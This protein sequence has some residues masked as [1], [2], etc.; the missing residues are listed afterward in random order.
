MSSR[1]SIWWFIAVAAV[2]VS[3]GIWIVFVLKSITPS[4]EE[5][6]K[7]Y[8]SAAVLETPECRP[9][10]LG[11][12]D[13]I[14]C[15]GCSV[16]E[17]WLG[18]K[19]NEFRWTEGSEVILLFRTVRAL[20]QQGRLLKITTLAT[21]TPTQRM[22]VRLNGVEIG[23]IVVKGQSEYTFELKKESLLAAHVNII[24]LGLPDAVRSANPSDPRILGVA[25][26]SV[27]YCGK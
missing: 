10:R 5:K 6:R 27:Q 18:E 15:E 24:E 21:S 9:M 22:R 14:R 12:T 13:R 17:S 4:A 20:D 8:E 23:S 3:F 26:S 19:R 7:Q 25:L 16:V 11:E 2:W 1:P